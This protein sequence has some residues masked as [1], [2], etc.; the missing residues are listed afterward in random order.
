MAFTRPKFK[1]A[2]EKGNESSHLPP[3]PSAENQ[4]VPNQ[5]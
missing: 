3:M 1:I 4:V 2:P 5:N